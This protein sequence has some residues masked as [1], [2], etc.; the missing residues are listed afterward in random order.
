MKC[1]WQSPLPSQA[2]ELLL[3][4]WSFQQ[5]LIT[6]SCSKLL[7]VKRNPVNRGTAGYR[8][9]F[10]VPS[11]KY[12]PALRIKSTCERACWWVICSQTG[13]TYSTSWSVLL[14]R[15]KLNDIWLSKYMHVNRPSYMCI[16]KYGFRFLMFMLLF[17]CVVCK[18]A[19]WTWISHN[20]KRIHFRHHI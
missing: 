2:A 1:W 6:S 18:R 11:L 16:H 5:V 13:A 9:G 12:F 10:G 3:A 8:L 20:Q 14:E 15:K 19:L 7:K 4:G 17:K